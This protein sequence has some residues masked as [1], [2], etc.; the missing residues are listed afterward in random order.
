[1][2]EMLTFCRFDELVGDMAVDSDAVHAKSKHAQ[3]VLVIVGQRAMADCTKGERNNRKL[4]SIQKR[5]QFS[6]HS[7]KKNHLGWSISMATVDHK[8][9][10]GKFTSNMFFLLFHLLFEVRQQSLTLL[11]DSEGDCV[12]V[13]A[14]GL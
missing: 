12:E 13:V 5:K 2:F 1:M 4:N 10:K 11:A 7:F 3:R 8:N 9:V 6:M 14:G